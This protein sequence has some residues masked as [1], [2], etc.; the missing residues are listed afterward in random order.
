MQLASNGTSSQAARHSAPTA[1]A[2]PGVA[3]SLEQADLLRRFWSSPRSQIVGAPG[4]SD[5]TDQRLA[6]HT[7]PSTPAH[8]AQPRGSYLPRGHAPSPCSHGAMLRRG[9]RHTG[10][11]VEAVRIAEHARV[12]RAHD[13]RGHFLVQR[14]R[15]PEN[16]LRPHRCGGASGAQLLPQPQPSVRESLVKLPHLRSAGHARTSPLRRSCSGN[17]GSR[18]PACAVRC[19]FAAAQSRRAAIAQADATHG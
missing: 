13:H 14:E 9:A 15:Q 19:T 11:A 16:G 7:K 1:Q 12:A 3:P 17:A 2:G 10:T 8:L 6:C 18:A 4:C 5:G